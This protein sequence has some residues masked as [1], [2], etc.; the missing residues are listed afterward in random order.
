DVMCLLIRRYVRHIE[1]LKIG[2]GDKTSNDEILRRLIERMSAKV[3]K[4][5]DELQFKITRLERELEEAKSESGRSYELQQEHFEKFVEFTGRKI[6]ES[7]RYIH[8]LDE[9][10]LQILARMDSERIQMEKVIESR[11]AHLGKKLDESSSQMSQQLE[12]IRA[13][14]AAAG[15][16]SPGRFKPA[17]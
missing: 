12:R 14:R 1:R 6:R 3:E 4:R 7:D 10:K 2:E 17:D 8:F 5:L 16:G 13:S 11:V 9:A 15:S